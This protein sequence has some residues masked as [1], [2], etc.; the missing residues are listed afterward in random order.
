MVANPMTPGE[1]SFQGEIQLRVRQ[2]LDQILA[3]GSTRFVSEALIPKPMRSLRDVD[4]A[5][6]ITLDED[7]SAWAARQR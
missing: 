3:S 5:I 4:E 7:G 6:T 2:F 1:A